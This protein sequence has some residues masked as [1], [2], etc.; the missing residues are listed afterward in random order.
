MKDLCIDYTPKNLRMR[1][2]SLILAIYAAIFSFYLCVLEVIAGR[3][4]FWFFATL[5]L[6]VLAIIIIFIMLRKKANP[7]VIITNESVYFNL[8]KGKAQL[9]YWN[10]IKTIGI[11]ISALKITQDETK[12]LDIDL[13]TLKYNDIKKLKTRII[14]LCEG[15]NIPFANL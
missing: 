5:G 3:Y 1:Y 9:S 12:T 7:L 11:G 2:P 15:K 13:G 8:E 4:N 14:E 10:D 6:F